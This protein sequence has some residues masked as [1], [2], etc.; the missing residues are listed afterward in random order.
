MFRPK[1]LKTIPETDL[2]NQHE[3]QFSCTSGLQ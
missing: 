3:N 2:E 1:Q